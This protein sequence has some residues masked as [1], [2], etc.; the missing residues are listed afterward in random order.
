MIDDDDKN[1]NNN[2]LTAIVQVSQC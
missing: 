1:S 2:R